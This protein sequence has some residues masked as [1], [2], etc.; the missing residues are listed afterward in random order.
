MKRILST[1]LPAHKGSVP[2]K[3]GRGIQNV[4]YWVLVPRLQYAFNAAA[5]HCYPG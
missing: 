2:A 1:V 3:A 4:K 5:C